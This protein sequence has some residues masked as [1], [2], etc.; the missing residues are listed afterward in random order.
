MSF[1]LTFVR[2]DKAFNYCK[3]IGSHARWWNDLALSGDFI[4]FHGM[5]NNA[6]GVSP[7]WN[8]FL[9]SPLRFIQKVQFCWYDALINV[10]DI[11]VKPSLKLAY[12]SLVALAINNLSTNRK[13]QTVDDQQFSK[14]ATSKFAYLLVKESRRWPP[15]PRGRGCRIHGVHPVDMNWPSFKLNLSKYI[16]SPKSQLLAWMDANGS[17]TGWRRPW[18]GVL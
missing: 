6:R 9:L 11:L 14:Q 12:N 18:I 13:R 17:S 15:I 16:V 3:I 8:Y 2:L 1:T 10:H 5:G 4:M 7:W